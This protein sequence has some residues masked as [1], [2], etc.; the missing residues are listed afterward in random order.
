MPHTFHQL[1][2]HFIWATHSREPLIDRNWRPQFLRL[3]ND[4]VKIRGGLPLRHNAMPDHVHLLARLRPTTLVSEFIG[5]V[6]GATSY[7]V[8]HELSPRFKLRWQEGYS[9]L[10]LR[11]DECEKVAHYIDAQEEHHRRGRVSGLLETIDKEDDWLS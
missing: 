1:Y 11:R 8:N 9:V 2:F 3:L 5:Q 7:R 4:E 10:S 6:K